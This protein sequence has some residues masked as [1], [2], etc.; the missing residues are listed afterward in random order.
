MDSKQRFSLRKSTFGAVS[1]LL[2]TIFLLMTA[3]QAAAEE[4]KTDTKAAVSTEQV[5]QTDTSTVKQEQ[6]EQV[7]ETDKVTNSS[8][9]QSAKE[10]PSSSVSEVNAAGDNQPQASLSEVSN[11]AN[12]QTQST[13]SSESQTDLASSSEAIESKT[14]QA[15]KSTVSEGG[16]LQSDVADSGSSKEQEDKSQA[17]SESQ[18]N[19]SSSAISQTQETSDTASEQPS[20]GEIS[21][22]NLNIISATDAWKKGYKGEGTVVAIIDTGLDV[23]HEMLGLTD[24]SKAKYQNQTEL[25]MAKAAAGIDY[26]KWYNNKVI[27]AHN[28]YDVSEEIKE[29]KSSS[30]G[31]HVTSIATG[32]PTD[33]DEATDL[34][35]YGVAPE[36]QVMLMRVFSDRNGSSNAGYYIQA[37]EDAV[38]LGADTINLSLGGAGGS[39]SEVG[40]GLK[41]AIQKAK[42]AGVTVVMSAGNDGYYSAGAATPL[43]TNPDYGVVGSPSTTKD[44]ISVASI[45]TD[46]IVRDALTIKNS[47]GTE[48]KA[49]YSTSYDTSGTTQ[50]AAFK[51]GTYDYVNAGK[52]TVK[53]LANLDLTGKVALIERSDLDF[54]QQVLNAQAK[55]AVGVVVFDN[56]D[57][58]VYSM[59]LDESAVSI[60]SVFIS[61]EAGQ[62]LISGEH[63]LVF[64]DSKA[65]GK[66][67]SAGSLS[68]FSAWGM[69]A[70]G[71]L[72]PDLTAPGSIIYAAANDNAYIDKSGTSMASPHVA[73]A[74]AIVKEYLQKNYPNITGS[75]LSDLVKNLLM[76]T[77]DPHYDKTTNAYSSPRKQGAGVINLDKATSTGL[78]VTGA[79][80]Y[81]SITLGEVEDSFGF[82]VVVHNITNEDKSLKYVTNLNTD[83]TD[84]QHFALTPKALSE[85]TGQTITVPA[86]GTT[87]VRI[88]VNA[89][90]YANALKN[91]MPNGYYLE[92]FVRF[93]D[94]MTGAD[95]VSIPYVGFRGDFDNLPVLEESIYDLVE[96]GK[97][98]NYV[99]IDN[100]GNF[101]DEATYT[102]LMTESTDKLY[103]QT[104]TPVATTKV[105]GSHANADGTWTLYQDSNGKT[106]LA[107]SP[108][109]DNNQ[110]SLTLRGTFLRNYSNLTA[111]V[112]V[113]DDAN[114]ENPIWTSTAG[115]GRKNY[116][117]YG[118]LGEE[119]ST[120]V[121]A[122]KWDGKNSQGQTVADGKY[123]YVLTYNSGVPGSKTQNMTFNIAVD[124]VAPEIPTGNLVSN[125]DGS[126]TFASHTA[127]DT[128]SGIASEQVF[129]LVK[130]DN[131]T[132]TNIATDSTTGTVT[133]TDNKVVITPNSNGTYTIPKGVELSKVYHVVTDYAGNSG[134]RTLDSLTSV[135]VNSGL[136]QVGLTN[137]ESFVAGAFLFTYR[138][139]D[140]NGKQVV[141]DFYVDAATGQPMLDNLVLPFGTYTFELVS[142]NTDWGTV[143]GDRTKKITLTADDSIQGV[144]FTIDIAKTSTVQVRFNQKLG[145]GVKVYA[146]AEDGSKTELA[147][148]IYNKDVY[149]ADLKNGV[150][151]FEA[152]GYE[153]LSDNKKDITQ[154]SEFTFDVVNKEVLRQKIAELSKATETKDYSKADNNLVSAYQIAYTAAKEAI[155]AASDQKTIDTALDN[156]NAA[157]FALTTQTSSSAAADS[158]IVTV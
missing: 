10:Q 44:G 22:S 25:E 110:D 121:A 147:G 150:Y 17:S 98:G 77:A 3:P 43:T 83:N 107:I 60:P 82:D 145:E 124:T 88:S 53:E 58:Y 41:A 56:V 49:V 103:S 68:D 84:G 13:V 15:A 21:Q 23:N 39:T 5:V 37:I 81:G 55:G 32:N 27:Y 69:T 151:T 89:S 14:E 111:A 73:G 130:G 36:A 109:A 28:Y 42:E 72:K 12:S 52:G 156:L 143:V 115:G 157:Y 148:A 46:E 106:Q 66:F 116:F 114:L 141:A 65:F 8:N 1:V 75:Q 133:M 123:K 140:S 142:Y 63:Q 119:K 6:A 138:V 57:E 29:T 4:L 48:T 19:S 125:A 104:Y 35:I 132:Y 16:Q 91:Q 118:D 154:N 158:K 47:D 94:T 126:F 99:T 45:N 108:N 96:F 93:L 51:N 71:Y 92:G 86:N 79:D 62:T 144:F 87:T 61:K 137:G 112:Y 50:L 85:I 97:P 139:T 9:S 40:D 70:D 136:V 113:A 131:G 122:T 67:W 120:L 54:N 34:S 30:H 2:G 128:G 33:E 100:N 24:I 11:A 76:S 117:G 18:A 152:D 129:Y 74:A 134:Y 127:S 80:N 102:A 31:M 78:Y 95:V 149:V 101:A 146:V 155:D 38:A 26:G 90:E 7:Q 20:S 64:D 153:F 135:P 59:F 105:L